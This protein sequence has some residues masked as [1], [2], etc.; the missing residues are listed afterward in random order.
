MNHTKEDVTLLRNPDLWITGILSLIQWILLKLVLPIIVVW[1]AIYI[2][3]Q[4]FTAEGDETKMKKAWKSVAYSG[5]ALVA[6][7][8]SYAIVSVL[9][10]LSL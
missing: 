4:L 10:T 6:I 2:A 3:Y 5:I 9:S 8:L 1:A 7:A